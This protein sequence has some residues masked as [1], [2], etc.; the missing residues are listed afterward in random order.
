MIDENAGDPTFK[1]Y[2]MLC[3]TK[4]FRKEVSEDI[5][6]GVK[7]QYT[8]KLVILIPQESDMRTRFL[9]AWLPETTEEYHE[10][11]AEIGA[12]IHAPCRLSIHRGHDEKCDRPYLFV[13]S[14]GVEDILVK[15]AEGTTVSV[16]A[17]PANSEMEADFAPDSDDG[18]Y[19]V[20]EQ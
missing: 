1:K 20:V 16:C 15:F 7:Q 8:R 2:P 9:N 4:F 10:L 6:H 19:D 14:K 3:K 12:P 5:G 11:A 18:N 13:W 17:L